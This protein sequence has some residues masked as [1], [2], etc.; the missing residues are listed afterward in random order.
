LDSQLFDLANEDAHIAGDSPVAASGL[1]PAM[2]EGK[3]VATVFYFYRASAPMLY[4]ELAR[5]ILIGC[6]WRGFTYISGR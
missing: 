2:V 5:E 3:W 6:P 1:S 4:L